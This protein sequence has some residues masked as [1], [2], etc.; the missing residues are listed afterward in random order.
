MKY[1]ST[2]NLKLATSEI[3]IT[4]NQHLNITT[5]FKPLEKVPW[6]KSSWIFFIAMVD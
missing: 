4:T 2:T 3:S 5:K 1:L 6:G